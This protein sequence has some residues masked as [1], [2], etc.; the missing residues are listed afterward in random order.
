[1][2]ETLCRLINVVLYPL[3]TLLIMN[4]MVLRVRVWSYWTKLVE[5]IKFIEVRRRNN[6]VGSI[7]WRHGDNIGNYEVPNG[8]TTNWSLKPM[9]QGNVA[10]RVS[11]WHVKAYNDLV[12]HQIAPWS[13]RWVVERSA[14]PAASKNARTKQERAYCV[15]VVKRTLKVRAFS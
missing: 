13:T 6:T 14:G 3:N 7:F 5:N 4:C 10:H 2:L 1:M 11:W 12:D 9:A 15:G 8:T